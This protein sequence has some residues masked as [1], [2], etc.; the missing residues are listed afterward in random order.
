VAATVKGEVEMGYYTK[1]ELSWS[2]SKQI[3]EECVSCGGSGYH[4]KNDVD[5]YLDSLEKHLDVNLG[6]RFPS[7]DELEDSIKWYDHE[8]QMRY[9]SK[10]FPDAVFTLRGEGEESGDVWVKYFKNGKMQQQK[11]VVEFDEFDESKL[12]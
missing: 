3:K 12:G 11:L 6:G 5:A 7:V 4:I 1:Y 10:K 2:G 8:I 9:L